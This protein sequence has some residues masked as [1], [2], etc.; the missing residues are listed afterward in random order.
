MDKN[1]IV[2]LAA[3]VFLGGVLLFM[4]YLVVSVTSQTAQNTSTLSQIVTFLNSS[5][6]PATTA[7]ATTK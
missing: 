1:T 3:G 6:K 4:G 2:N 5:Q 7:P